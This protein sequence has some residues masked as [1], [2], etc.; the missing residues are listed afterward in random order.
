MTEYKKPLS[1]Q[2]EWCISLE[3]LEK[4]FEQLNHV[5]R[6]ITE[7]PEKYANCLH[8]ALK[9]ILPQYGIE[10]KTNF[11]NLIKYDA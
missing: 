5:D 8:K 3:N 2:L 6:F 4:E 9:K 11:S 10:Y 7:Q 1:E